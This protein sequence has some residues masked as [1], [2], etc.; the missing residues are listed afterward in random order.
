MLVAGGLDCGWLAG[1]IQQPAQGQ[2]SVERS[3][4]ERLRKRLS[5]RSGVPDPPLSLRD[6]SPRGAGGEGT[7][8]RCGVFGALPT[9]CEWTLV[10]EI[11]R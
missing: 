5:Y 1:A 6:I 8:P 10:M 4:E 7:A 9:T 11:S 3:L 2:G